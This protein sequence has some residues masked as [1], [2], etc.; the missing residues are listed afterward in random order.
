MILDVAQVELGRV[1]RHR[2]V[3]EDREILRDPPGL[4]QAVQAVEHRLGATDGEAGDEQHA[5]ALNGAADDVGEGVLGVARVV[6]SIAVGRL[7]DEHVG[8]VGHVRRRGQDRVVGA[9]EVAG[10]EDRA[11]GTLHAHEGGAQDVARRSPG[12]PQGADGDDGGPRHRLQL[13]QRG[14]GLLLGVERLCRIMPGEAVLVGVARVLFLQVARVGQEQAQQVAGGLG[15]V[16]GA[17]EAL[18]SQPRQVAGVVD[19]GV[20]EHHRVQGRGLDRQ[21]GPV[22][23]AQ[24]L[25]AL[26]QAAVD[27]DAGVA[28]LDQGLAAG[29]RARSAQE[30]DPHLSSSICT[31]P[32]GTRWQPQRTTPASTKLTGVLSTEPRQ[33][34][35]GGSRGSGGDQ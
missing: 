28:G 14:P 30:G 4:L 9:A 5:A 26:E 16:H 32:R 13:T 29:D 34:P 20:G 10:E 6:Q 31:Y 17:L 15:R 21:G 8:H 33:P 22:A 27:Q 12:D 2:R 19:V 25:E 18:A 7:E 35:G 1:D 11:A 23:L 3:Q 24:G